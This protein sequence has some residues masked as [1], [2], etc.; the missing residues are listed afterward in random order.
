MSTTRFMKT[1]TVAPM[2]T[3][4]MMTGRSWARKAARVRRPMPSTPK[5]CSVM[6]V[7]VSRAAMSR[8][9]IVTIGLIAAR[10]P[11]LTSTVRSAMPLLRAVRM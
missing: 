2:S 10:K 4:P 9:R 6:S 8:P 7:P 11:C 1:T 5:I 3:L